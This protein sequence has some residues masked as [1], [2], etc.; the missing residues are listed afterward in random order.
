MDQHL[1]VELIKTQLLIAHIVLF[2]VEAGSVDDYAPERDKFII[3]EQLDQRPV[4]IPPVWRKPFP[5]EFPLGGEFPFQT[6]DLMNYF[7]F[8]LTG[9]RN[10]AN[11][12]EGITPVRGVATLVAINVH[13]TQIV[14]HRLR[15]SVRGLITW[16]KANLGLTNFAYFKPED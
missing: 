14:S 10:R 5:T 6:M 2:M 13:L 1:V 3:L 16:V 15:K 11:D 7:V 8:M 12:H 9:A 4:K